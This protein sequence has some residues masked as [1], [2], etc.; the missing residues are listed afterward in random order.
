MINIYSL[1]G[2]LFMFIMTLCFAMFLFLATF[3]SIN[4]AGNTAILEKN[5]EYWVDSKNQ[6]AMLKQAYYDRSF[7]EC[8]LKRLH[9]EMKRIKWMLDVEVDSTNRRLT[10]EEFEIL[11]RHLEV[12]R[13]LQKSLLDDAYRETLCRMS[14]EERM[15][16]DWH[17]F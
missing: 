17:Y 8:I 6:Q 9:K 3:R 12:L 7:K 11:G 15:I 5:M 1:C 16:D 2:E 14:E 4:R 13:K 10:R